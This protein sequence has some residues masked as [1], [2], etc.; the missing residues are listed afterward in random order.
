MSGDLCRQTWAAA[1]HG[2]KAEAMD[3][4]HPYCICEAWSLLDEGCPEVKSEELLARVLTNPG[5]YSNGE[6]LTA[7]LTAATYSGVSLIRQGASD[8]E[9]LGT[10][11]GLL[12]GGAEPQEL[13]GAA[14]ISAQKIRELDKGERW[15]GVY[16]TPDGSKQLHADILA[17]RVSG[18]NSF[19]KKSERERRARLKDAMMPTIIH[20]H[21]PGALLQA[22][23]K[24]GI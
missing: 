9:I 8:G 13:V 15:F 4:A 10:I 22:L 7:K 11:D 2:K 12:A 18:T 23:R 19:I 20:A 16:H 3:I 21:T 24:A 1:D 5:H 6:M 17:T 14:V